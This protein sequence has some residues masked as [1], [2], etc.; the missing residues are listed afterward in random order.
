MRQPSI[1]AKQPAD[2][3][4]PDGMHR[5][6]GA[7]G[8]RTRQQLIDATVALLET[9]GLRDVSVVDVARA[10]NTSPATF[11]VYFK[12]VPEAVLAALESASQTSPELE[13]L[14]DRDWLSPG[15]MDDARMFVE[16]YTEL[17]NRNRNIFVV[18][19]LAA[20]EG[21]ARFYEARMRQ[22]R[23]MMKAISEQVSR[24]QAAGR[25]PGD[26]SPTAC[27][28]TI[29]MMLERLAAVGPISRGEDGVSYANLKAAA[30]HHLAIML[31]V[32]AS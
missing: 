2:A 21:D 16:R 24:A 6:L 13:A 28:G 26:L 9:N 18:R 27:S 30:A 15:A 3:T 22:A 1:A 8:Q 25:T 32:H 23:P 4:S 17:W 7:K 29:L 11:Y 20:E 12:G 14:I 31:G 5:K 10:A 19:N